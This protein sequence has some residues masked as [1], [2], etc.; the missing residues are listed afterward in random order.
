M[1]YTIKKKDLHYSKG[2]NKGE[3]GEKQ[4]ERREVKREEEVVSLSG[5]DVRHTAPDQRLEECMPSYWLALPLTRT[6]E[7]IEMKKSTQKP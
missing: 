3:K 4:R 1:L 2:E 6:K 7:T 5:G